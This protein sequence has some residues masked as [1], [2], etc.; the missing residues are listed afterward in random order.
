V[1]DVS[2]CRTEHL[3]VAR[4]KASN[5]DERV[6]IF[7]NESVAPLVKNVIAQAAERLKDVMPPPLPGTSCPA[8]TNCLCSPA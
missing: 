7:L 5:G 4:V 2:Q 8:F 6:G 3:K 1:N